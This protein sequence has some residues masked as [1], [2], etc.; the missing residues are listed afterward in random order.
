MESSVSKN[1]KTSSIPLWTGPLVLIIILLALFIIGIIPRMNQQKALRQST[2]ANAS[3]LPVVT[4][5][6]TIRPNIGDL[7]LPGNISPIQATYIQASAGGYLLK[8][9]VDIGSHVTRGELLATIT[10]PDLDS[11]TAQA[12]AQTDQSRAVIAQSQSNLDELKV[13]VDEAKSGVAHQQAALKQADAQ[14]QSVEAA[15]L[16]SVAAEGAA[17]A[18]LAD[19]KQ[20]LAQQQAALLQAQA[21]SKLA[22]VTAKRYTELAK[23]GYS[24]QQLADQYETAAQSASAGVTSAEAVVAS[25]KSNIEAVSEQLIS[26]KQ[27]EAAA[28]A[29]TVAAKQ[30]VQSA[31]A[32]YKA[33]VEAVQASREAVTAG[34]KGVQVNRDALSANTANL[35]HYADLQGFERVTAPFTG[36]ITERDVDDGAL[37]STGNS[38]GQSILFQ[39]ART[40]EVRVQ[41]FVPQSYI[42]LIHPGLPVDITVQEIPHKVFKGVVFH[43][44]GALDPTTRTL[45]T[46]VHLPNPGGILQAGMFAD[47]HFLLPKVKGT[48]RIPEGALIFD[49]KGT[50]VATLTAGNRVHYVPVVVGRDLGEE[51]EIVKGLTGNELLITDPTDGL[52]EGEEVKIASSSH[53]GS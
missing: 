21:N 13:G 49:S 43:T 8:R 4:V 17:K 19:A 38:G 20:V 9:Y 33:S 5:G 11:Q 22:A 48:L 44:A 52:K 41:A 53:A 7:N 32:Q 51:V 36:V 40:D 10:A 28:K 39:E 1:R 30:N 26:A 45:L 12:A 23:K 47:M 42:S 14:L 27:A 46:E 3:S 31:D 35:Q 34:M 37:I 2:L 29:N 25:A 16:Q 24:S 15:Q 50:R 18:N 6:H